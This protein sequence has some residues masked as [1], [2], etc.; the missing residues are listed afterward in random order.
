MKFL[1][2]ISSKETNDPDPARSGQKRL[3]LRW[4][5]AKSCAFE[6]S[7]VMSFRRTWSHGTDKG[8]AGTEHAK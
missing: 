1:A 2:T 5:S 3:R 6:N 8:N 7:L 4:W